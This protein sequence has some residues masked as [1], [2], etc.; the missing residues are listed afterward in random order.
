MGEHAPVIP[1]RAV[2][3]DLDDTLIVEEAHA[4]EV[5]RSTAR[6]AGVDPDIW[7]KTLFETARTFWYA[8]V[9]HPMCA[10]LGI[11][12]WEGLW[13]TFAGG[14]PRIAPLRDFVGPYRVDVWT[15]TCESTGSDPGL[16]GQ[17]SEM[18]IE[19]QRAGHPLAEGADDL[20]RRALSVGPVG[21]V[22]NG[23]ADI[24]RLKFEQTGLVGHFSTVVISGETGIAKPEPE[25]F[26][27]AVRALGARPEEAVMVG[28]S[29]ERDIEGA[30]EAGL[31]A[32][33][34]S[35]GRDAP[36]EHPRIRVAEGA[37]GVHFS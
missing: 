17:L 35:H 37:A 5:V 29:W 7:E 19:G 30:L 22:T 4:H 36:R 13:A 8:S 12:S 18:Y 3:L 33:W 10:D 32:I 20:V 31:S 15:A 26:L 27:N 14:H 21:L 1:L 25:V 23:P 6:R 24:Q 2:L 34:I 16:A 28:D 11:S 9:H